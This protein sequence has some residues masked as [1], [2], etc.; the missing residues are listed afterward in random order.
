MESKRV[1]TVGKIKAGFLFQG[2]AGSREGRRG[3][4]G[5]SASQRQD[6]HERRSRR[7]RLEAERLP[8]LPSH[9]L[10]PARDGKAHQAHSREAPD[11]QVQVPQVLV[12]HGLEGPD[13][14]ALLSHTSGIH[15]PDGFA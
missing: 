15:Q 8:V 7:W 1:S 14:G 12:H 3:S 2:Q 10:V 6:R 5:H 13:E 9:L 11:D 4:A